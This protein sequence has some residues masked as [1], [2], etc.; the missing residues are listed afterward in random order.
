MNRQ[1]AKQAPPRFWWLAGA[2][3]AV[4]IGFAVFASGSVRS[5]SLR[6]TTLVQAIGG[7]PQ[8][9]VPA[10]IRNGCGGCHEI[11]G[12]PGARGT[13]GP[14]LQGVVERGY[15]GA[16]RA[17]PDA[18]MRWISRARD[19]DPNTAMPNTNLSPQEARDI[20]AYLYART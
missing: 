17:S 13:V 6:E 4:V 11:P 2:S 12:V 18:M 9:A 14:S 10:M 16:S 1:A 20:T 15:I 3:A 5:N 8:R 19:V 7:D